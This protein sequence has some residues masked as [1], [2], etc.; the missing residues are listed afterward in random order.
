M[1]CETE[2]GTVS[3]GKAAAGATRHYLTWALIDVDGWAHR[4]LVYTNCE[5]VVQVI[6]PPDGEGWV[7][8]CFCDAR[9]PLPDV[10]EWAH[11]IGPLVE[12]AHHGHVDGPV[13]RPGQ[14]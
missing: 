2:G 1:A 13:K 11:D 3:K 7:L 4:V 14:T 8:D 10:P 9:I 5:R 12:G 6:T